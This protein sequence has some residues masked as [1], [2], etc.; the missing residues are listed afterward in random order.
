MNKNTGF[1][2]DYLLLIL[3]VF[4]NYYNDYV[5]ISEDDLNNIYIEIAKQDIKQ[6]RAE[7]IENRIIN[8]YTKNL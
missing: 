3:N 6:M 5:N 4:Q 1:T 7:D 2:K 8:T